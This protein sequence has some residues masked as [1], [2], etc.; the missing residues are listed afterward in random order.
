MIFAQLEPDADRLGRVVLEQHR[1]AAQAAQPQRLRERARHHHVARRVDLPE[2]A[3]IAF[4]GAVGIDPRAR[5]EQIRR[6]DDVG[7]EHD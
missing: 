2:Q 6:R 3:G 7:C 1:D 4:D 5:T